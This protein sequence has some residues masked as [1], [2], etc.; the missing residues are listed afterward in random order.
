MKSVITQIRQSIITKWKKLGL[1]SLKNSPHFPFFDSKQIYTD[2][3]INDMKIKN[4]FSKR[5][6]TY[7]S[8]S[9]I[10]KEVNKRL[11]KGEVGPNKTS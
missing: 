2:H 6:S 4:S 10:Q 1:L 3:G 8:Q 11:T 7:D 5:A 9:F